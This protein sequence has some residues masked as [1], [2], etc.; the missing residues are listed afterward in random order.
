MSLL[1]LL[2]EIY[3]TNAIQFVRK[4]LSYLIHRHTPASLSSTINPVIEFATASLFKM[5]SRNQQA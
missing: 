3:R 2:G 4:V 5:G 1:C